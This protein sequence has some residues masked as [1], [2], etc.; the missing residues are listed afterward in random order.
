MATALVLPAV[1][2][3]RDFASA[4]QKNGQWTAFRAYL[5]PDAVMFTPEVN[6]AADWL[7][8][9][10]DPKIA[11]QWWPS[12]TLVSCDGKVAVNTGSWVRSVQKTAG[13]FTTVWAEQPDASWKWL[14]DH[15]DTVAN[16][17]RI[18]D[19]LVIR[20]A[21][22]RNNPEQSKGQALTVERK[23][24]GAGLS[25]DRTLIWKYEV[26]QNNDRVVKVWLWNGRT[27][28]LALQEEVAG[29]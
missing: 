27:Y 5:A 23:G 13:Y 9:K 4:A 20:R 24:W 10:S 14:L 7:K 17:R 3:E 26:A 28:R 12:K 29:Q 18:E 15:G 11:V 19:P 16:G 25:P 6:Q 2:A 1:Q 21:S 8:D 22:C